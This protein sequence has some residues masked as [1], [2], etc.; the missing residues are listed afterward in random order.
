M[1]IYDWSGQLVDTVRT[2]YNGMYEATEPSTSSYNCPL[3][4]GPC[5]GMYYFKGNDPGVPG[6][7]N[8]DY[9][10]RFRTIGTNFQAWPGLYTVTDTAPTQVAQVVLQP[11]AD[12]V[13]NPVCDV[14]GDTPNIMAVST[15]YIRSQTST[16]TNNTT[17][18]TQTLAV[19]NIRIAGTGTTRSVT[20]SGTGNLDVNGLPPAV[21][22]P[23]LDGT[24]AAGLSTAQ[25][26][27]I[28]ANATH[29]VTAITPTSIT[30]TLTLPL[31]GIFLANT[32]TSGVAAN[33]T[34]TVNGYTG[35]T[36]VYHPAQTVTATKIAIA[37]TLAKTV[38]LTVGSNDIDV[39]PVPSTVV[40]PAVNATNASGLSSS[41]AK[42]PQHARN[43]SRRR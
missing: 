4:A 17:H 37:G 7:P 23:T 33:V 42:R 6:H 15:P 36:L 18:Q 3:P 24:N 2:D 39:R 8:A 41:S 31:S 22:L 14:S 25:R 32:S 43:R 27:A 34:A 35:P 11:G 19:N 16:S 10:P 26:S 20:I 30:F 28:N 29:P 9:N 12:Q 1:G 13:G 38:T 5:P 21:S 40:L